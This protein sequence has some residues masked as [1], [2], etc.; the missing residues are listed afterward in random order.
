MCE[1]PR[2][3]LFMEATIEPYQGQARDLWGSIRVSGRIMEKTL[4]IK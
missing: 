1:R 4:K 2:V 3:P